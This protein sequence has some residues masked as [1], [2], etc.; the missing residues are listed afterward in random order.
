[1]INRFLPVKI[2]SLISS[3]NCQMNKSRELSLAMVYINASSQQQNI[4]LH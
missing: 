2:L 1:M 3:Y 4:K